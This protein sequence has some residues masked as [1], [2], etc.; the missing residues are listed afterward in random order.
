MSHIE[1]ISQPD[2][3]PG[4]ITESTVCLGE[5][6][7]ERRWFKN[8]TSYLEEGRSAKK[9]EKREEGKREYRLEKLETAEGLNIKRTTTE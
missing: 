1:P 5:R 6:E 8:T 4:K 9:S 3:N 7:D 2:D